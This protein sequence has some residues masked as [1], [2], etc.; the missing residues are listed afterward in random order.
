V[1]LPSIF[2]VVAALILS[3]TGTPR[4]MAQAAPAARAIARELAESLG[5]RSARELAEAGGEAAVR[6]VV[7]KAAQEGGEQL[8]REVAVYA[9]RYGPQTLRAFRQAP[10]AMA[11]SMKKVP[12][13][14]AEGAMRAAAREPE[15]IA[16]LATNVGEDALVVAAKHPGV[17]VDIGTKLGREGCA[18]AKQLGTPEAI[19]LARLSDDLARLPAADRAGLM[20]RM[21]KA[22]GKVID[23][24]EKH[25]VVLTTA[26]GTAAW[27]T[28]A[29]LAIDALLGDAQSPGFLERMSD[30]FRTPLG[31]V[32][33]ALAGLALARAAWW[34]SRLRRKRVA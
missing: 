24:L 34:W 8:A 29:Y 15:A 22:P 9:Q 19:R 17:G 32:I 10:A 27:V 20:S 7:E 26:A 21:G 6:E 2:V 14:F 31:I 3:V 18:V 13:E 16:R 5:Q 33:V 11:Q 25:P 12:A 23:Y 30:K 4:A 1:K 28:T